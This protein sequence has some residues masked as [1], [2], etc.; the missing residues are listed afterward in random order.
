MLMLILVAAPWL[1]GLNLEVTLSTCADLWPPASLRLIQGISCV[2]H[3]CPRWPTS[4]PQYRLRLQ[5]LSWSHLFPPHAGRCW[6]DSEHFLSPGG[7]HYRRKKLF[8]F[9]LLTHTVSHSHTV[10]YCPGRWIVLSPGQQGVEIVR[11]RW[12]RAQRRGG[13]VGSCLGPVLAPIVGTISP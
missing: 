3:T 11:C 13:D 5:G 2:P 12:I 1:L 7:R 10:Q 4:S 6:R 9:P 8:C